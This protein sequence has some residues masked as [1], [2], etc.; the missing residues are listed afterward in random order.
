MRLGGQLHLDRIARPDRSTGR[1][2]AHDPGLAH[3][4][5]RRIP[6]DDLLQQAV[7]E[8]VDLQARVAQA[9]DL[10]DGFVT[11]VQQRADGE[12]EEIDAARGDVLPEIPRSYLVAR[13]TEFLEQLLVD[14]MD[15]AQIRLGGVLRNAGTVLDRDPRMYVPLDTE[16]GQQ[17]HAVPVRLGEG[18]GAVAAH[19]GD[20]PAH[21]RRP[22]I[23]AH[24]S[25]QR[26]ISL[27]VIL[28]SL[29]RC[30]GSSIR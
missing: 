20:C 22:P 2:D 21:V 13:L 12:A 5:A 14:Q 28:R 15:L 11:E 26:P 16:S 27:R 25:S 3:D 23:S 9:G 30:E 10:D 29:R 4:V 24:L 8:L 18:V 19:H 1:D 6:T 7:L 17:G